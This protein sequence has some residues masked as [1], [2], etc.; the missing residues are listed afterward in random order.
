MNFDQAVAAHAGWKQKL[1][2]HLQKPDGSLKATEIAVDN[3]CDLGKSL[4]GEGLKFSSLPEFNTLYSQHARFHKVAADVVHRADRGEKVTGELALGAKSEFA[5]ASGV[6]VM[7][8]IA[9]KAKA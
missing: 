5:A 7:A 1:A 3:R 9:M 4:A 8:I 2:L 6:V